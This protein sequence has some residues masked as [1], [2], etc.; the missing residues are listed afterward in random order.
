MAVT[1][2]STNSEPVVPDGDPWFGGCSGPVSTF[3]PMTQQFTAVA[4]TNACHRG[5]AADK[6]GI[7]TRFI[8]RSF[9]EAVR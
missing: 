1:L 2:S 9:E 4:G 6:I 5:L 3:S 7:K 8:S